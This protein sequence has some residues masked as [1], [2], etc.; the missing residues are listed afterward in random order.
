MHIP[1]KEALQSKWAIPV[2][3]GVAAFAAGAI[4][5]YFLGKKVVSDSYKVD[6]E[7]MD[8]IDEILAEDNQMQLD[9]DMEPAEV[10]VSERILSFDELKAEIKEAKK[11]KPPT[12]NDLLVEVIEMVDEAVVTPIIQNVFAAHSTE[13]DNWDY[14]LEQSQREKD[15]PYVIHQDEFIAD[16]MDFKQEVLTYYAQDDIMADSSETPIYGWAG[17]MGELLFG[18]GSMDPEVVYIRNEK[19]H[20]EWEVIRMDQSF[21]IEVLGMG[22]DDPSGTLQHSV[23]KFR[24]D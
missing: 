13:D 24:D 15:V 5:G 9:Y 14:E 1:I 18:H 16:E 21:A 20:M 4:G 19:I 10:V 3:V 17:L 7:T 22:N 12:K 11:K 8:L 6:Q 2:G 23:R